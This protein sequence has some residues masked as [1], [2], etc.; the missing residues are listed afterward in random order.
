[1]FDAG[2]FALTDNDSA[3]RLDSKDEVLACLCR[4]FAIVH[5]PQYGVTLVIAA[6]QENVC[7]AQ[8]IVAL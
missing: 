5:E 3:S 8:E 4:G 1:M 7:S 6:L 2:H